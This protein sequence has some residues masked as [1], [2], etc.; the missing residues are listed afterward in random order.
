MFDQSLSLTHIWTDMPKFDWISTFIP[1]Q[2]SQWLRE[3][4]EKDFTYEKNMK[5]QG[6]LREFDSDPEKRVF[7]QLI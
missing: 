3:I 6:K 1:N 4:R 7:Y 5:N 2:G